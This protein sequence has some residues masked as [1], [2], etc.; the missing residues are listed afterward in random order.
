MVVIEVALRRKYVPAEP[1]SSAIIIRTRAIEVFN[2][3]SSTHEKSR[4]Y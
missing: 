3:S 2:F 1:A 4:R